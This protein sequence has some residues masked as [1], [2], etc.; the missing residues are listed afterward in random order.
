M[1]TQTREQ[2]LVHTIGDLV[3]LKLQEIFQLFN[4]IPSTPN[5][6]KTLLDIKQFEIQLGFDSNSGHSE[7]L[8]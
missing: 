8:I 1:V 6:A 2:T 7:I 5:P 4:L 3:E